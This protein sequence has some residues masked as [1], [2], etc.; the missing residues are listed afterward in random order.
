MSKEHEA[1]GQGY[2][3]VRDVGGYDRIYHLNRF[4]MAMGMADGRSNKPVDMDA[5]SW[6][7]KYNI[8]FP[9]SDIEQ[10]MVNQAMATIPTDGA[11]LSKRGKSE[12][13]PDTNKKSAVAKV[14]RNKYGI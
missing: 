10:M 7:E 14:K 12:E 5:S 8:A 2:S 6:Y 1:G 13:L 3:L 4:M 11:E 9:F